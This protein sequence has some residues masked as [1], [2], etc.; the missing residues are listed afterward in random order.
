MNVVRPAPDEGGDTDPA[1][2]VE[3]AVVVGSKRKISGSVRSAA[4]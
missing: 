4:R 1:T 2:D 3:D